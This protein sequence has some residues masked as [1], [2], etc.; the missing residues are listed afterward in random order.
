MSCAVIANVH[1][2]DDVVCVKDPYSWTHHLLDRFLIRFGVTHTFVDGRNITDIENAIR[3]KTKVLILESPNS[4]TF[5]IRDLAACAALA[6]RHDLV[7]IIENSYASPLFQN[8]AN[9]GIDI[10]M[11]TC[12]KY[13][14][15]HSDVV[16]GV[17]Y[18][19]KAMMDKIF[20]SELMT[21]GAVLSP[22]DAAL[23]IRGL[24]TL[25]L[26]M[27]HVHKNGLQI[28]THLQRHPKIV[29]VLHP[30]LPG[31]NQNDLAHQQMSG[32][33]GL[34]SFFWMLK[35]KKKSTDLPML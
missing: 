22:H 17:L 32:A 18:G 1:M 26:R 9:F 13:L 25:H 28:A 2:G 12:S 35:L 21:L 23:I 33:G 15:G 19:T 24:R 11:H 5:E 16:A 14:N 20:N 4:I 6:K 31:F 29:K 10:I 27:A 3:T 34:F 7:T 8:P 30:L